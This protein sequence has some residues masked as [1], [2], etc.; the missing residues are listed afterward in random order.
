MV[1][2]RRAWS[3]LK[4]LGAWG[5][6]DQ[7]AIAGSGFF[8]AAVVARSGGPDALGL[9]ALVQGFTLLVAGLLKAALGD[10]LVIEAYGERRLDGLAIALPIV[11]GHL[12]LGLLAA[13]VWLL[14]G[15]RLRGLPA[16]SHNELLLAFL[17]PLASF[18]ELA[19]SLRL[20]GVGERGLC[21]GDVFVALARLATIAIGVGHLTGLKLGLAALS[22]G[23][24]VSVVTIW[25][26][27]RF[28]KG[29]Q[30]LSRLWQLGRWLVGESLLYGI[31]TYGIWLLIVP[32]AGPGVAGELR[33]GQQLFAPI[34]TILI[35]LNVVLLSPAISRG[36]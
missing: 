30:H 2:C 9:F 23:G 17:L 26:E 10:P 22:A 29:A 36:C 13:I 6:L 19:R 34:Q 16:P 24:L 18:Q 27:L 35:G 8:V 25:R 14:V 11:L 20:A 1:D 3:R 33:A 21:L 5:V 32:R 31:T 4:E 15:G 28:L 7:I 12:G